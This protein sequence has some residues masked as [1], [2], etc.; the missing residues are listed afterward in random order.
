MEGDEEWWV[1]WSGGYC[2]VESDVEWT[3][4]WSGE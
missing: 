3:V 2:E 4:L 1:L